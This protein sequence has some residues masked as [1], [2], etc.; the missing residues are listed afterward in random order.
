VLEFIVSYRNRAAIPP[1]PL[2]TRLSW[3][4]GRP[5]APAAF[6]SV[7]WT[8]INANEFNSEMPASINYADGAKTFKIFIDYNENN[9]NGDLQNT[10]GILSWACLRHRIFNFKSTEFTEIESVS[11]LDSH[12]NSENLTDK[13][14][15]AHSHFAHLSSFTSVYS[16]CIIIIIIIYLYQATWQIGNYFCV[17][18]FLFQSLWLPYRL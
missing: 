15:Y 8:C 1:G 9:N 16:K 7:V 4:M 2:S 13:E 10:S 12:R 5:V 18:W 11:S 14:K 6:C 17:M 3:T